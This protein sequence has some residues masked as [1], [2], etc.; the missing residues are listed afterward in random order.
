MIT[1]KIEHLS[2]ICVQFMMCG[3]CMSVC[4]RV[5]VCVCVRVYVCVCVYECEMPVDVFFL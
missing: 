2:Y 5:Y 1:S 4:V 3:M